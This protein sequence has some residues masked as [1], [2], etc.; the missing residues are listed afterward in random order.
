MTPRILAGTDLMVADLSCTYHCSRNSRG[1]DR[2]EALES[3]RYDRIVQTL[4]ETN[5][6]PGHAQIGA[7]IHRMR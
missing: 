5:R 2:M 1:R 4:T 7:Q 6:D 3:E